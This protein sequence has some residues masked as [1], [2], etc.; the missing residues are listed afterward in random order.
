M[1]VTK[2]NYFNLNNINSIDSILLVNNFIFIDLFNNKLKSI[3]SNYPSKSTKHISVK[4][5][6]NFKLDRFS[7][8]KDH[9]NKLKLSGI[10]S[11]INLYS[12]LIELVYKIC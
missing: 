12:N 6:Y 11:L 10:Y 4:I 7:I 5:Y 9:K 1:Y 3:Y 2:I 8:F